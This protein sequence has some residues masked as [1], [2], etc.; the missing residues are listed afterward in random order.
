MEHIPS[1]ESAFHE[2]V[3]VTKPG[4]IV[5][6]IA[7]PLWNSQQGHHKGDF[8]QHYPWIHLRKNKDEILEYCV[9]N[10]IVDPSGL[11]M[12]IHVE[13]MLN[14]KYFNKTPAKNY[15]DVCNCLDNIEIIA[16]ELCFDAES[17]L[18]SDV[19]TE[20]EAKGY[21]KDELLASGHCFIA[22]KD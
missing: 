10:H 2:M 7:A 9:K 21:S 18:T 14:P 6:S 15:V 5:Y 20:L 22:R 13:Y 17:D 8:F 12:S 3:R 1:I 16:N 4:G 11:G 19:Y